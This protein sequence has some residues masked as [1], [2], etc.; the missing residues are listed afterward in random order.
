MIEAL[1][2]IFLLAILSLGIY[3]SYAF[4]IKLSTHNRLRTQAAA[5]A[6][7]NLEAIRAMK[8]IDIGV[9]GGIP[10]GPLIARETEIDNGTTFT[11]RTSVRYVDDPLDNNPPD[12]D[13]TDYKQVE[14]KVDWPT[15]ME[16]KNVILNTLIS[17]PRRESSVGTGVLMINTVDGQGT[18]IVGAQVHIVNS[19]VNPAIDF[20]EET[21]DNGSLS[22]PGVPIGSN[23]YE[24][25]VSKNDYETVSTYPPYPASPFNPIDS[26]LTVSEGSITSKT[27]TL[28]KTSHLNISFKDIHGTSV[29]D[30]TFSLTGGRIIGTTVDAAPQPVYFYNESSLVSNS[31]G[32]WN[33]PEFGKGPYTF[34][35]TNPTLEHITSIPISPWAVDANSTIEVNEIL[36][37]NT[38]NTLV[39]TVKDV[40]EEANI[41]GATVRITD[42]LGVVFQETTTDING[43]AYFPQI[44]NPAKTLVPGET[45]TIDVTAAGYN[46]NQK[47]ETINGLIRTR[48]IL[49]IP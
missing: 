48:V 7:K 26:H 40:G 9:V 49:T 42:S 5:I 21:D 28:D 34:S 27:F 36:V 12:T 6:E 22:L 47:T 24:V 43:I 18:P 29:P 4:G 8:Y 39:V 30:L 11:I 10:N 3:G 44:E 20:Y 2:G 19:G 32:V 41:A 15:N 14:V 45:Y 23:N 1:V 35:F 25:T 31:E 38:E 33:S 13:P 37:N 17:P 16:D 46:P